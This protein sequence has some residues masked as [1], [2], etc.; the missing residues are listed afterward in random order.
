MALIVGGITISDNVFLGQGRMNQQEASLALCPACGYDLRAANENRCSECGKAFNPE[1]LQKS[2]MPWERARGEWGKI[3]ALFSTIWALTFNPWRL[4]LEEKRTH[5]YKSSRWFRRLLSLAY[6]L[7][8]AIILGFVWKLMEIDLIEQAIVKLNQVIDNTGGKPIS[9]FDKWFMQ[10]ELIFGFGVKGKWVVWI[11]LGIL[12]YEMSI[13][14]SRLAHVRNAPEDRRPHLK[15]L[16]NYL[17]APLFWVMVF[18]WA[19]MGLKIWSFHASKPMGNMLLKFQIG[20]YYACA[21]MFLLFLW[22]GVQWKRR[23]KGVG[24]TR[25]V[26]EVVCFWMVDFAGRT[27]LWL[28]MVPIYV[29]YVRMMW[30]S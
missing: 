21:L 10:F 9:S 25:G 30:E 19:W 27:V 24:L 13:W 26:F 4:I 6:V 12:G 14:P 11:V 15:A 17:S 29:G 16:G 23:V 22:R 7:S 3:K 5:D 18:G 2:W 28:V 20:A 1:D 8:A